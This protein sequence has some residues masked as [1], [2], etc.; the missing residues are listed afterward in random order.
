MKNHIFIEGLQGSG[1]TTLLRNLSQKYPEYKAYYEGDIS[2]AELA[3]CSYMTKAQYEEALQKYPHVEQE[4]RQ[5]TKQEGDRYIVAYTRILADMREFYEWMESFEIYNGRVPYA[6]FHDI[7]MNRY[8][9]LEPESKH[10]YECSFFQ[11]SMEDMMLYYQMSE[12]DSV[13]FY[14]EAYEILKPKGF[15]MLY[16]Q[17]DT[18]RE[19]VLQIKK[20]RSDENGVEL[21][22]PLMLKY[23][24]ESPYGKAHG[25]DGLEDMIAHFERRVAIEGRIIRE[26]LKE[27]CTVLK[28]KGYQM[29]EIFLK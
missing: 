29:E 22:Y 24:Q 13:E 1:K 2:P 25:F 12:Q 15:Q 28:A 10:L 9:A 4:I 8:R 17:S 11:N 18:I 16:L 6:E 23:L 14:R 5:W 3:W 7:I 21:W 26:V 27:D 19:N 20:E